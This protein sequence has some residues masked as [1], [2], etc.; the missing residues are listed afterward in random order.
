MPNM[1]KLNE[2]EPRCALRV[3]LHDRTHTAVNYN[4]RV[5]LE[6]QELGECRGR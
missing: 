5:F 2:Q 1:V 6:E 3:W 4:L